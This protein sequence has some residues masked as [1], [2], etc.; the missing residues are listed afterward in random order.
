MELQERDRLL[1][2]LFH[3]IA[4]NTCGPSVDLD[5]TG[6][7]PN[8]IQ[9]FARALSSN[10]TVASLSL[11]NVKEAGLAVVLPALAF[12]AALRQLD[13]R[14]NR[15]TDV[16]AELVSKLLVSGSRLQ[17]LHLYGNCIG[18]GG[19]GHLAEMLKWNDSLLELN[20]RYNSV[21][22]EG[23]RALAAGLQKN[24][25]LRLLYLSCNGI[26]AE[27]AESLAHSLQLNSSLQHLDLYGNDVGDAGAAAFVAALAHNRVLHQL[28]LTQTDP[29]IRELLVRNRLASGPRGPT[30]SPVGP[31]PTSPAASVHTV[32]P[33]SDGRLT[34]A[35]AQQMAR[36]RPVG[37][38]SDPVMPPRRSMSLPRGGHF[39]S[40]VPGTSLPPALPVGPT[41][42][43][44]A[45]AYPHPPHPFAPPP[46]NV[47]T[48]P[49]GRSPHAA[50]PIPQP[51]LGD[52]P[53]FYSDFQPLQVFLS[54]TGQRT[55][56]LGPSRQPAA[57][58]PS[59]APVPGYG[60]APEP[61]PPASSSSSSSLNP[62]RRLSLPDPTARST[63]HEPQL[64]PI[65]A[66][67]PS[68]PEVPRP[69][70][71]A[72]PP[73][74]PLHDPVLISELNGP[75]GLAALEVVRWLEGLGLAACAPVLLAEGFDTLA[76]VRQVTEAD[77]REMRVR[78]ADRKVLL[79]ALDKLRPLNH[80]GSPPPPPLASGG[81]SP[82]HP[83]L[84]GTATAAP[85][86]PVSPF[87]LRDGLPAP[88]EAVVTPEAPGRAAADP[89]LQAPE[90][91]TTPP[92]PAGHSPV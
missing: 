28:E 42:A 32:G 62:P 68:F 26:T 85:T 12:N 76:K 77:C 88:R 47:S 54:E 10:S 90:T 39:P 60:P 72:P 29:R 80:D 91:P 40:A 9:A 19:C 27:G 17:C 49:N 82:E 50:F 53:T 86:A 21:G 79:S 37:A 34:D 24:Q 11:Q 87:P 64:T 46:F 61:F 70:P 78:L 18:P 41:P 23:A 5:C 75:S 92:A 74:H 67:G 25:A 44:P 1:G 83:L 73:P 4:T 38:G 8:G 2:Q 57:P 81:P 15:L 20:L 43:L 45:A 51:P 36:G 33:P 30:P 89:P 65:L 14:Y 69:T 31:A 63:L 52:S 48:E 13:L 56:R 3:C 71:L 7:S 66:V 22:D 84:N 59:F 55:V 16:G 35:E 58:S 6:F